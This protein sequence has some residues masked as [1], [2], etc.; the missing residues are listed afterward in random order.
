MMETFTVGVF[1]YLAPSVDE[2]PPFEAI[3][4]WRDTCL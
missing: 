3:Q 1:A 2:A 4:T